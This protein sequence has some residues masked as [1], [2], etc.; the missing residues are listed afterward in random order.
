[1]I[2][3]VEL[4]PQ[5]ITNAA[6]EQQ[7]VLSLK[8]YEEILEALDEL[9]DIRLYDAAKLEDDGGRITLEEYRQK[10]NLP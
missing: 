3:M 2:H 10:R 4:H 6:G 5:Y 1:M 7:V 8:E 9:E